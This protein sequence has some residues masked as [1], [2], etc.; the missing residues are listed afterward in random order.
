MLPHIRQ[1]IMQSITS[2]SREGILSLYSVSVRLHLECCV[3]FC[4]PSSRETHT[5][6]RA[7]EG[8]NDDERTGAPLLWAI[9]LAL[10]FHVLT[11]VPPPSFF[12][13]SYPNHRCKSAIQREMQRKP[14]PPSDFNILNLTELNSLPKCTSRVR[15]CVLNLLP[16]AATYAQL[17]WHTEA[18]LLQRKLMAAKWKHLAQGM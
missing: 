14:P 9:V 16:D 5:Y 12:Y 10:L 11:T 18:G 2:R 4:T 17:H 15:V 3:Q 8:Q 7:V 1:S 13:K 6:H